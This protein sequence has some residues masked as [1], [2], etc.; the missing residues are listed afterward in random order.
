VCSVLPALS[1]EEL[2]A[3]FDTIDEDKSGTIEVEELQGCADAP[4]RPGKIVRHLLTGLCDH[5]QMADP[6]RN[7]T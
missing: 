4:A 7:A 6:L 5:A 1:D 2:T 3:I